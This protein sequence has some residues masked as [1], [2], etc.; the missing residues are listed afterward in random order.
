MSNSPWTISPAAAAKIDLCRQFGVTEDVL[1]TILDEAAAK[2]AADRAAAE[3]PKIEI[4][5][6]VTE[7]QRFQVGETYWTRSACDYECIF[8]YTVISRTEKR[9]VIE[10]RGGRQS[11]RGIKIWSGVESCSPQGR[12]SMSPTITADRDGSSLPA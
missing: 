9:M 12:F 4:L 2:V 11:T 10:D 8:Q 6:L 1:D 5:T 7:D 3:E